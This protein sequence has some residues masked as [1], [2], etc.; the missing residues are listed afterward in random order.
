MTSRAFFK[1]VRAGF[2]CPRKQLANNLARGLKMKRN[3]IEEV[4]RKAG[5]NPGQRAE[6]LTIEDWKRLVLRIESLPEAD[7]FGNWKFLRCG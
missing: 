4:M 6:T 5:T 1:V 7:R 2:S 3:A